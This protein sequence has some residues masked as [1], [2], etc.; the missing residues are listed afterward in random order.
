MVSILK[1]VK[2]R[3]H[4]YWKFYK[5]YKVQKLKF[6]DSSI[7][8]FNYGYSGKKIQDYWFY[9]FITHHN[10]NSQNKVI[11]V[12]SVFG[13]KKIVY[14]LK[15][16]KIFICGEN[17]TP[18]VSAYPKYLNYADHYGNK[19][20]LALGFN[21]ENNM[22]ANY[23]RHPLWLHYFIPPE[24]TLESLKKL[25]DEYN[26]LGN[27]KTINRNGF[28]VHISRHDRNGI[29]EEIIEA[30]NGIDTVC[31]A[32]TFMNNS[33]ELKEKYKDDKVE[34]LKKF[35]FNICP[36]NSN[37]EGYVTEKLFHAIMSGC[38]PVYWGSNNLPEP[39]LI[40]PNAVL[41]YER[42]NKEKLIKRVKELMESKTAYEDF[43]KIPPFQEHAAEI[44]WEQLSKLRIR[45]E[46][47]IEKK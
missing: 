33:S 28:A 31:C 41:F 4:Y 32:G 26:S 37:T 13:E 19:V 45:M 47:I 15:G 34:F 20:D 22:P 25:I 21:D 27:R 17:L 9:R 35:K 16:I 2:N 46:E 30:M 42:D 1:K 6:R 8:F 5:S 23:M 29:R 40:N 12:I 24:S 18:M 43:L 3:I 38:I 11:N 39:N 44:I 7:K 10:L 36:E 14:L